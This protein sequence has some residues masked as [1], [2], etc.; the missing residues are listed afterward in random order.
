MGGWLGQ[1]RRRWCFQVATALGFVLTFL[2]AS[3]TGIAGGGQV[4]ALQMLFV[5]LVMDGP[6]AMSLDPGGR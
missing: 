6:P 4:T 5:N 2:V 3:L 1:P